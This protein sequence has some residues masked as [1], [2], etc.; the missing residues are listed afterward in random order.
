MGNLPG[1]TGQSNEAINID[2][3]AVDGSVTVIWFIYGFALETMSIQ[4]C[5]EIDVGQ[6]PDA[7]PRI[8]P[9]TVSF[10]ETV[11]IV[12]STVAAAWYVQDL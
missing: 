2:D 6:I 5:W 4:V 8:S 1:Q 10:L 12:S 11:G 9:T 7:E 3:Y